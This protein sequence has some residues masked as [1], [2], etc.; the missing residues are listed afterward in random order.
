MLDMREQAEK[1]AREILDTPC[2]MCGSK[3]LMFDYDYKS[4]DTDV[5]CWR[6]G[7]RV[8]R[9]EP[10]NGG[11]PQE[12]AFMKRV[13]CMLDRLDGLVDDMNAISIEETQN[14]EIL[15][16][17]VFKDNDLAGYTSSELVSGENSSVK[18][19]KELNDEVLSTRFKTSE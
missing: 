1:L 17:A 2:P 14:H 9:P 18:W 15:L 16:E 11:A 7:F 3:H 19:I 4:F 5:R 10:I 8:V 12:L 6:C 13:K